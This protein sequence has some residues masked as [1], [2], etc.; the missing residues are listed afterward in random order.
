MR[1]DILFKAKEKAFSRL[2]EEKNNWIKG[3]HVFYSMQD[4][5]VKRG[6]DKKTKVEPGTLCQYVGMSAFYENENGEDI[7]APLWEHD[8][9]EIE[10]EGQVVVAEVKY[11]C[12]MFIL[13]S[14]EFVDSY[15][16]LFDVVEIEDTPWVRGKVVGNVFDNPEL[17][18][19]NYENSMDL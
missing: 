14:N 18:D 1:R 4:F 16:P 3:D 8:L 9:L 13:A 12:G 7:E 10:Y 11:E 5:I 19:K 6:E 17:L 15:I 2:G